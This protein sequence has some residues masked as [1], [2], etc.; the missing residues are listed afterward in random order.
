M[1]A[2]DVPV[3][4]ASMRLHVMKD[5]FRN[6]QGVCVKTLLVGDQPVD[7]AHVLV[8]RVLVVAPVNGRDIR[9]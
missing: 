5:R 1:V 2:L 8:A 9:R 7:G 4:E 6:E 3:S